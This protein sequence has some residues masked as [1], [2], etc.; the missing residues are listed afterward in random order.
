VPSSLLIAPGLRTIQFLFKLV[1]NHQHI[2]VS[3]IF[4]SE[5]NKYVSIPCLGP[6]NVYQIGHRV[7]WHIVS[8]LQKYLVFKDLSDFN[9]FGIYAFFGMTEC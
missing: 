8:Q 3:S 1:S 4:V 2:V 6:L 7:Q 5:V 9:I